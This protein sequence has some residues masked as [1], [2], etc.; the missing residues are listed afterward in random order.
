[1]DGGSTDDTCGI[2]AGLVDRVLECAPGR[3]AQMNH[4][5]RSAHGDTLIFL[6]ADTWLHGEFDRILDERRISE[7]SWGYF[8]IRLSGVISCSA[9]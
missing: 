4:G 7:Q 1:M 2:A 3:A 5:A 6:H 9:V 8:D